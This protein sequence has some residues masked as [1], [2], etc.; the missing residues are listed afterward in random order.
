MDTNEALHERIEWNMTNHAPVNDDVVARFEA[1]REFAKDFS[2]AIVDLCPESRDRSLAL[3]HAEDSLMRAV[4]A[5]A[6]NQEHLAA[7][8]VQP[9]EAA[10]P[11]FDTAEDL[12]DVAESVLEPHQRVTPSDDG[13]VTVRTREDIVKQ[14]ESTPGIEEES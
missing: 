11:T 9:Y 10:V 2:H 6:R 3:T 1:L 4:A 14:V 7:F 12:E 8:E 5:I 13:E